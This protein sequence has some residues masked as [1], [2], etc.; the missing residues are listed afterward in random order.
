MDLPGN[1]SLE[2]VFDINNTTSTGIVYVSVTL[3]NPSPALHDAMFE[4]TDV[5]FLKSCF[6]SYFAKHYKNL[7]R[8]SCFF[9][10]EIWIRMATQ[11]LNLF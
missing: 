11:K 4:I 9:Q 2:L 5:S 3:T 1:G 6:T 7:G 8:I 10:C